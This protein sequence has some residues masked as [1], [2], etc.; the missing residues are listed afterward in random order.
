MGD[1]VIAHTSLN[2]IGFIAGGPVALIQAMIDCVG[3]EGTIVMPSHSPDYSD[4]GKW[5]NPPVPEPW[6]E[7]IRDHWPAFDPRYTPTMGMG[8]VAELFRTYPGVV[9]SNHPQV[10]FSALGKQ[11]VHVT[12]NHSLDFPLGENSPLQKLYDLNAKILLLGELFDSN[13][14]VHLAESR[15]DSIPIKTESAAIFENGER[16]WKSYKE[17]ETYEEKFEEIG[18]AFV[19]EKEILCQKVG[20]ANS[21]LLNMR[22]CVD[23]GVKFFQ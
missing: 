22:E 16:V 12:D 6:W 1:A 11:A 4:P 8:R 23:F 5:Q 18:R 15:V 7:T 13:T 20:V 14:S 3:K 2:Q 21:Y 10:S 17:K 9:R 19:Q